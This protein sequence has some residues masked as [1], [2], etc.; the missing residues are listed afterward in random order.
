MATPGEIIDSQ[1]SYSCRQEIGLDPPPL[2]VVHGESA[3]DRACKAV[4]GLA[5]WAIVLL[6]LAGPAPNAD[7]SPVPEVVRLDKV[8]HDP[9]VAV[10]SLRED[11]VV[12][13]G[14]VVVYQPH[15]SMTV[16]GL[17]IPPC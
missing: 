11:G 12:E 5:E 8:P 9:H 7:A 2:W 16:W 13:P 14:T 10:T 3:F 4:W 6:V 15:R 17:S 1:G